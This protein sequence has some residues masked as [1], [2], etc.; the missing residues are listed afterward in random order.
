MSK[1]IARLLIFGLLFV[2][3]AFL[4]TFAPSSKTYASKLVEVCRESTDRNA[5]YEREVLKLLSEVNLDDVFEIIRRIRQEDPSY[6]FCH[7]LAH[8]LGEY[9]VARDPAKWIEAM[10]LN[11]A[12][13]L[14][15]NGFIHGVVGG[16][17][18]AEV[19]D[20]K[21]LQAYLPD[22]KRAC[23]PREDWRPSLLDQ[24]ICYHGMGHLYFFITDAD[25]ERSLKLC[26]DTSKSNTADFSRVCVEGVF[27]Q[28]YQPL[29]PDDFLMIE[30]MKVKPLKDTVRSYCARFAE[31]AYEGACLRESWPF[32]R[33][34]LMKGEV[35]S[36]CSDQPNEQEENACYESVFSILGR[37]TLG[38]PERA[39]A[40]CNVVP[41]GRSEECF[42]RVA[43]SY[44]EENR[45][46]ARSAISFCEKA[47]ADYSGQCLKFLIE[48]AQFIFGESTSRARFCKA[49]PL[50]R[51]EG[52]L[53]K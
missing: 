53:A 5:C 29:E 3:G 21:T 22:F 34:E 28:I 41:E 9:V 24:A 42:S 49:L 11:P 36:F 12:D 13:G 18:R 14:C 38:V 46:D 39:I 25:V 37:Q 20:E 30:R 35:G 52:C 44:L 51:A 15:S 1:Q 47:P 48:R 23:E 17:F 33:D 10:S 40:V 45:N 26:E 2:V 6:Q 31:D 50:D 43:M 4:V 8:S 27:M 7:V 32:F 16:R 19:L